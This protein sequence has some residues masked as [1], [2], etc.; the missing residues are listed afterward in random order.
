MELKPV[1]CCP[2]AKARR[3]SAEDFRFTTNG[4]CLYVIALAWLEKGK[5]VV[6]SIASD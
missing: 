6:K 4:V 5:L 2:A 1:G 3:F